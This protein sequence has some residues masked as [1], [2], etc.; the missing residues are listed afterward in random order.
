MKSIRD[1][2]SLTD[3]EIRM[4]ESHLV[5]MMLQWHY[6][7]TMEEAGLTSRGHTRQHILNVAPYYFG[8]RHGKNWW[9]WQESGW[10]GTAMM[11]VAGPIID[12]VDEDFM[13]RLPGRDAGWAS[14][15]QMARTRLHLNAKAQRFMAEYADELRNHDR[16]AVAAR[17]DRSGATVVFNGER[18]VRNFEEIAARYRDQWVGPASFRLAESCLRGS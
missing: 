6:M 3:T 11:E 14:R 7:F 15:P 1:P 5:A 18:M 8:S 13:L 9:H 10:N 4:V 12:A 2:E 16:A 17:Y